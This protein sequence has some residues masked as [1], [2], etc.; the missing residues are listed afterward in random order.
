MP[1]I[2]A[3]LVES[4]LPVLVLFTAALVRSTF[5]FGD[6]LVAMPLLALFMPLETA[7]PLVA[8]ISLLIA[9]SVLQRDWRHAERPA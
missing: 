3:S 7:A 9:G 1:E 2:P 4:S 6:A 5:G 8:L